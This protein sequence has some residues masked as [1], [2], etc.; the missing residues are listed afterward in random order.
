MFGVL[1]IRDRNLMG[2]PSPFHRLAVNE[3]RPGPAFG[4]A[5][6][7][8]G[9][10]RPLHRIRRGTRGI[11]DLVDL[12]KDHIEC[13]GETLMHQGRDVAFDEMRFVAV[14]ADQVGQFLAADAGEHRRVGNLEPIEMKDR[15]NGTIACGIEKLVGV[16]TRGKRARFRLTIADD[17]G[18]DQIRIVES[19]AIGMEEGIAEFAAFMDRAGSFRRHMA[20]DP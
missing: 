10:T 13:A 2:A 5:E 7:D 15:K 6:H 11:L 19:S 4:R 16:P 9:P 3:L 20:G 12:R 8:H 17:A 14:A 18:D 1:E